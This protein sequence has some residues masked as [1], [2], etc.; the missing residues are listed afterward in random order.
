MR[1]TRLVPIDSNTLVL[2]GH[3]EHPQIIVSL[4]SS[5]RMRLLGAKLAELDLVDPEVLPRI[6]T[7]VLR[8]AENAPLSE[9]II[10]LTA[11]DID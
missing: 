3:P 1:D 10:E 9:P 8:L 7:A 5:A 11:L 4:H 2:E 6:E